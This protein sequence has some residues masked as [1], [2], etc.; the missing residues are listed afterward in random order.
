MGST[1]DDEVVQVDDAVD[2]VDVS[3]QDEDTVLVVNDVV[4]VVDVVGTTELVVD[5]VVLDVTLVVEVDV[6]G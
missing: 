2:A 5:D 6:V 4:N 1:E 3:H